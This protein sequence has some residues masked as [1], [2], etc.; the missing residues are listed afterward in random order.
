MAK[1]SAHSKKQLL[2]TKLTDKQDAF[3][4]LVGLEGYS[5]KLAYERIYIQPDDPDAVPQPY[6]SYAVLAKALLEHP[7]IQKRIHELRAPVIMRA[8]CTLEEHLYELKRIRDNAFERGAWNA[9]A[10]AEIARGKVAGLYDPKGVD[11]NAPVEPS[12]VELVIED[13]SMSP[14]YEDAVIVGNE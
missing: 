5:P 1:L 3:C 6:G 9:A 13:C 12:K 8:R 4:H 11:D 7:A 14:A 2:S 10:T